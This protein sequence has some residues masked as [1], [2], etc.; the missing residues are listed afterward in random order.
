MESLT[1]ENLYSEQSVSLAV[2]TRTARKPPDAGL[3]RLV[4]LLVAPLLRCLRR[5]GSSSVRP[6]SIHPD[7]S[8]TPPQPIV[9]L[10]VRSA[11]SCDAHPSRRDRATAP[12]GRRSASRRSRC[13]RLT[14]HGG[15]VA[16][17]LRLAGSAFYRALRERWSRERDPG[18][19][20][21]SWWMKGEA[22][23]RSCRRLSG[24]YSTRA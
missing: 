21:F 13:S 16:R 6:L 23:S 17:A 22:R 18:K 3:P 5:R 24:H 4:V 10:V 2:M 20:R 15:A 14:A 11:H 7:E 9:L 1:Q 19:G 8:H 12:F